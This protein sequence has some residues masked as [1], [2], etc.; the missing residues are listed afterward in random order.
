MYQTTYL[1]RN[2]LTEEDIIVLE[3]LERKIDRIIQKH[4]K[5]INETLLHTMKN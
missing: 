2:W 5:S 4:F 1:K 3:E